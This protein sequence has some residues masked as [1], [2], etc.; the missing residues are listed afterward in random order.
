MS[1]LLFQ[2]VNKKQKKTLCKTLI[3]KGV[4]EFFFLNFRS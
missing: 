2:D 3:E 1:L 4:I